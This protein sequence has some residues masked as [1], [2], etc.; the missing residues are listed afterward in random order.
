MNEEIEYAEMLEIPVSTVNVIRKR[1]RRKKNDESPLN[2]SLESKNARLKDSLI[3]SV[4][5]RLT[6]E[7]ETEVP[8]E[9]QREIEENGPEGN[10]NFHD[11][12][13]VDTVRLYSTNEDGTELFPY[14]YPL[15][16]RNE[17]EPKRESRATRIALGVEF[18]LACALCSAIFLTNVFVPNSAINTFFR[19]MRNS[20]ETATAK[21]Y[22]DFTLSPVVSE[23]SDAK[24]SLS[25]EGVLSFTDECCVYPAADGTV[26]E[27]IKGE[28]GLYTLKISHSD[29][30]TG[31]IEGL[32]VVY[33]AVGE[34]IKA[35][36]PVGF[37]KGEE[38]VR[39][40]MYSEG[41]LLN[42]FE[43]TE[44]NCLAWISTQ[45]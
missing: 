17:Y 43:L 24:L 13:R 15:N 25:P 39:F 16:D 22:T 6:E 35:N 28:D 38:E 7:K 40:T 34:E 45:E 12:E 9:T 2:D 27:L 42:C 26:C 44:E 30:F 20:S 11:D 5:S 31:V 3:E 37:S 18:G 1:R 10:I 33:Y 8:R 19:S 4:N 29:S 14:D 23:L 36:V 21:S 41:E 32:N